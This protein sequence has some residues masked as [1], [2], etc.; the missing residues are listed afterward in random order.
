MKNYLRF[1]IFICLFII[2]KPAYSQETF[3]TGP[4]N[5]YLMVVGG[6]NLNNTGIHEKIIDI[7][8]AQKS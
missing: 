3:T 5:G 4:K 2:I 7:M 8:G 1:L 6:G